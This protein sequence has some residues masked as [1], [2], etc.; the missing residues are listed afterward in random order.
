M[1]S[2]P[3]SQWG[4]AEPTCDKWSYHIHVFLTIYIAASSNSPSSSNPL[5][6]RVL[7]VFVCGTDENV[8]CIEV[9]PP[10]TH[11]SLSL[12]CR[13]H[14]HTSLHSPH[15]P[16]QGHRRQGQPPPKHLNPRGGV[17]EDQ[18]N[19]RKCKL[20][21][22]QGARYR[23]WWGDMRGY[24]MRKDLTTMICTSDYQLYNPT[25]RSACPCLRTA[26]GR[27]PAR[28]LTTSWGTWFA[29]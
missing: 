9:T 7:Q 8:E 20:R 23:G 26:K 22:K 1:P 25:L 4:E 12:H 15:T 16:T 3:P 14:P 24:D 29:L 11:L 2:N 18:K 10:L 28:H 17:H 13:C 6:N 5:N 27:Q 21:P 19:R